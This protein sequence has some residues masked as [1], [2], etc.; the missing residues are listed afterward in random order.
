MHH[1]GTQ[2]NIKKIQ[3]PHHTYE[4]WDRNVAATTN[5]GIVMSLQLQ[6]IHK[7][8]LIWESGDLGIWASWDLG[9]WGSED[10]GIWESEEEEDTEEEK[11]TQKTKKKTKPKKNKKKK[12][13]KRRP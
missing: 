6:I 11:K 2:E 8:V 3:D 7:I 10:L 13:K 1:N 4:S 9:I 12:K 5:R